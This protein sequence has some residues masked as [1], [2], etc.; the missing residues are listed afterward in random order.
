MVIAV[1]KLNIFL[2]L[3]LP[4]FT[5]LRC[6]C[7]QV[8]C[9]IEKPHCTA[10]LRDSQNIGSYVHVHQRLISIALSTSSKSSPLSPSSVL[11]CMSLYCIALWSD[12]RRTATRSIA[13]ALRVSDR[14][15]HEKSSYRPSILDIRIFTVS[16][17]DELHSTDN[18]STSIR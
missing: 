1:Y 8:P 16:P 15:S 18:V 12:G 7:W 5:V 17:W 6:V 14:S 13:T 2:F 10:P 4:A 11:L 9:A 3:A